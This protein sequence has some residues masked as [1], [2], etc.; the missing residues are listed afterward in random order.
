LNTGSSYFK[1]LFQPKAQAR[2]ISRRGLEGK[3]TNGIE[4]VIDLT[5]P[6]VEDDAVIF[7]TELSCPLGI[8]KW[9]R[10]CSDHW[11]LPSARVGGE[12]EVESSGDKAGS[13][14]ASGANQPSV[15]GAPGAPEK[16]PGLPVE[17]SAVRHREGIEHIIYALE[18]Y[19]PKLDT[20]CKFWTFFALARLFEVATIP[21]IS[22]QILAWFYDTTNARLIEYHP[23]IAYKIGCGIQCDY[24]TRDSFSV[25]V[26]EDALLLLAS[27]NRQPLPGRPPRTFHGRPREP[28]LDDD[29][30][31]RI[32][33]ARKSFME[34]V[35]ERFINLTGTEMRWFCELSTFQRIAKFTPKTQSEQSVVSALILTCKEYVRA[36]IAQWLERS[37]SIWVPNSFASRDKEWSEDAYRY[38]YSTMRY[39][40]RV[41]SRAFWKNLMNEHF[42]SD[43]FSGID[44]RFWNS[45]ISNLGGNLPAF[46]TQVGADIK[47]VTSE[48]LCRIAHQF[49]SLPGVAEVNDDIHGNY[50]YFASNPWRMENDYNTDTWLA[51]LNSHKKALF[52]LQSFITEVHSYVTKYAKD[53]FELG[54]GS[55]ERTD[56]VTCLT[57][58]EFKY[59]PLWAG[60]DDD[61]TGGVFLDQHIPILET[62]GFS[63]PGPQIHLGSAASTAYSISFVGTRDFEST[64]QG[65][66]HRPTDGHGA[67]VVSIQ[68]MTTSSQKDEDA[69]SNQQGPASLEGHGAADDC[70]FIMD[71]SAGDDDDNPFGCDSDS[72]DTVVMDTLSQSGPMSDFEELDLNEVGPSTPSAQK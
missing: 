56:T 26:G 69:V 48:E 54:R 71:S 50:N 22:K 21:K 16:K 5:P 29:E 38:V 59:L 70:S 23:E 44:E 12:D 47:P 14:S 40:E 41:L 49:N 30:L 58:N 27:S 46:Q 61:G 37:G 31:Q 62:G 45:S 32:E 8:R 51:G 65:A 52:A 10:S 9:A 64:V 28:L 18:G 63:T 13:A 53:M 66:S 19:D 68:S 57:E 17:Y 34:Y 25:L 60:G 4:Y 55:L 33:Y 42:V 7:L 1:A 2:N 6:S 39:P 72:S 11:V 3:L 36:R 24:L 67:D 20:P 35:I 15:H 43:D